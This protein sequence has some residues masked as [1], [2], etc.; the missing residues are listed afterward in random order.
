[1][2]DIQVIITGPTNAPGI[3]FRVGIGPFWSRKTRMLRHCPVIFISILAVPIY[4]KGRRN[5]S[6]AV[7]LGMFAQK[8]DPLGWRLL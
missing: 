5:I 2:E 6:G 4:A 3:C 7:I 8:E 1:M